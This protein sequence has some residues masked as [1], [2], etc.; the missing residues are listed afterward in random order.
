M[1]LSESEPSLYSDLIEI[2]ALYITK[3]KLIG[4][5]GFTEVYSKMQVLPLSSKRKPLSKSF[6]LE[7]PMPMSPNRP[8][9]CKRLTLSSL[10]NIIHK[11]LKSVNML[12]AFENNVH[13]IFS[14]RFTSLNLKIIIWANVNSKIYSVKNDLSI[15]LLKRIYLKQKSQAN[16]TNIVCT[17]FIFI[18]NELTFTSHIF[19]SLVIPWS[20]YYTNHKW[21]CFL[22][23]S[24]SNCIRS[25]SKEST[26]FHYSSKRIIPSNHLPKSNRYNLWVY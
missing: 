15:S 6:Q 7:I 9:Y 26:L 12:L 5:G 2:P 24:S 20:C 8:G 22:W 16:V 14:D 21:N 23:N 1:K 11:D 3:L 17:V 13:L 10:L 25:I 19:S 4:S 18:L